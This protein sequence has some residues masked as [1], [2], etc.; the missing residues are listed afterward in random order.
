MNDDK[1]ILTRWDIVYI[2]ET[3]RPIL[4][5]FDLAGTLKFHR[6]RPAPRIRIRIG[7]IRHILVVSLQSVFARELIMAAMTLP[8]W[9]FVSEDALVPLQVT[10]SFTDLLAAGDTAWEAHCTGTGN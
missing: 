3:T 5:H 8:R 2:L 10:Q 4:G 6:R 1:G 7:A 9:R